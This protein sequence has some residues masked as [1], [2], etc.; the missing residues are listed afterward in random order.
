MNAVFFDRKLAIA[1]VA[2][3]LGLLGGCATTG[4]A[5]TA[6]TDANKADQ[7]AVQAKQAADAAQSQAEGASRSAEQAQSAANQ[8]QQKA[9]S[10]SSTADKAMNEVA[11]LEQKIDRMFKKT[12]RK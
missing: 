8:A 9:D 4:E 5:S 1:G 7:T 6:Q 11:Q 12:M 2:L 10:A 3:C